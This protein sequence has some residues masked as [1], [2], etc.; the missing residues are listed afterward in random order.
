MIFAQKSYFH[1][2]KFVNENFRN[3]MLH[4]MAIVP[5][6]LV[7]APPSFFMDSTMSLKVKIMEG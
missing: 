7:D 3:S 6:P 4:M 2:M 1:M 5:I